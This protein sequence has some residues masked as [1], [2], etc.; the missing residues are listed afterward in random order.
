MPKLEKVPNMSEQAARDLYLDLL[1]KSLV[2]WIYLEHEKSLKKPTRVNY[3]KA[4]KRI[5]QNPSQFPFRRLGNKALRTLKLVRKDVPK[6]YNLEQRR[7]EGRDWSPVAH[8]MIGLERL[9]NIKKCAEIV[10]QDGVEGDFIETGVW[11]GGAC[12]FMRGL[13]KA[14]NDTE[15]RVWCADSFEGLPKPNPEKYP[16]DMKD[17]YEFFAQLAISKEI[18]QQNFARYGL[19]DEQVKFLK[20]WF[21]DTLPTAPIEKIAILRLDGDMYESTMDALQNLYHKIEVG[22]FIIIDDFQLE[23]C[24]MAI[25][26]FRKS[27]SDDGPIEQIDWASAY[28]RKNKM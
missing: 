21:S 9:K 23:P 8:T 1:M 22:G 17:I 6:T 25:E 10:F 27:V 11:R 20:G 14:Y 12:I 26:D 2:N 16:A 24:R 28:W 19:L 4:F 5:I 15:R 7:L 18:V 13:L 3:K